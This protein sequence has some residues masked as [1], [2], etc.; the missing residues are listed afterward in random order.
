MSKL[1]YLFENIGKLTPAERTELDRKMVGHLATDAESRRLKY[2]LEVASDYLDEAHLLQEQWG[3]MQGLS[4]GFPSVDRLTKGFVPGELTIIAGPTSHGKTSLAVNI[5]AKLAVQQ[6]PVLFVTL[7]MTKAQ[8]T[9]R[10]LYAEDGFVD[11][12]AHVGFQKCNDLDWQDVRGLIRTAAQELGVQAV[13]IDHLHYFTR[14]VERLSED[15]GRITKELKA[16]ADDNQVPVLLISH[17][18]RAERGQKR[19]TM[20]D[21]RGS[22][23]IAQDA[24]VVLMV[25]RPQEYAHHMAITI[26]KNRNRGF[27]PGNATVVLDFKATKLM[28]KSI[29]GG[30]N[31][32]H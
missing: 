1:D 8:L 10:L 9:S 14:E 11:Y 5:C 22:S 27:D 4:S 26:E 19:H 15:L 3:K 29:L 28:E 18:R 20:D 24:D 2:Q 23:Y 25:E 6:V 16:A 32:T 12:S 21:L 13:I 17:V 30:Y 7:E 31:G